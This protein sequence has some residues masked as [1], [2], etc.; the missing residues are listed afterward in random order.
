VQHRIGT[1]ATDLETARV[2]AHHVA[3]TDEALAARRDHLD[4]PALTTRRTFLARIAPL[5]AGV[6]DGCYAAAGTTALYESSPLQR[7]LRDVR[8]LTQHA[9]LA[10][11]PYA[12]AGAALLG[13]P[14][15][16]W[17]L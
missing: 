5:A 9:V 16:T 14:L 8:A 2:L 11:D 15:P 6:V 3:R 1:L 10:V 17:L 7:R 4:P 12:P 13:E